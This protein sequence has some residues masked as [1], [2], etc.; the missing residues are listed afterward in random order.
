MKTWFT[1]LNGA[2]TLSALALL[3]FIGYAFM[4]ARY[5]LE[6]WI[7]GDGASFFAITQHGP[8]LWTGEP[9]GHEGGLLGTGAIILGFLLI[10]AWVRLRRGSVRLE[11]SVAQPPV[12]LADRD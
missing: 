5:F 1:S 9:Y 8:A 3:S 4:E 11:P 6:K 10:V 12:R 7:P 2:I